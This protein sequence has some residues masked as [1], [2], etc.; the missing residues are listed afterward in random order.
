MLKV[1][2]FFLVQAIRSYSYFVSECCNSSNKTTNLFTIPV[3]L[4]NAVYIYY[5]DTFL[6][7]Y[8]T[9]VSSDCLF[10]FVNCLL[11]ACRWC[12]SPLWRLWSPCCRLACCCSWPSSC[13]PSSAWS[14]T[15]ESSI[16][17]AMMKSH[18]RQKWM[19]MRIYYRCHQP[20]SSKIKKV[21]CVAHW[22][23]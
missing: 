23:Y 22:H 21:T 6:I 13:S 19:R 16:L 4:I 7:D 17:P 1:L 10:V 2:T 5:S 11:Q 15:W 20:H 14:S 8:S 18:V 9:S 12:S 3:C